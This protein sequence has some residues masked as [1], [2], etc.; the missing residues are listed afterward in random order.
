MS[1]FSRAYFFVNGLSFVP[2]I[3]PTLVVIT[4][5]RFL[6]IVFCSQKHPE[7]KIAFCILK[8]RLTS[9]LSPVFDFSI[10]KSLMPECDFYLRACSEV[11]LKISITKPSL[12]MPLF[13]N[14]FSF[15][16]W[17]QFIT[18]KWKK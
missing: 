5:S 4:P 14:M 11:K 3:N 2:P 6:Y 13:K 17:F 1:G 18:K 10:G 8:C 15:I 12:I 16:N 9:F 7:A